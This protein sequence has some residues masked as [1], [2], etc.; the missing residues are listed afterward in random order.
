VRVVLVCGTVPED[1]AQ[2]V[3]AGLGGELAAPGRRVAVVDDPTRPT[4]RRQFALARRPG[5]AEV[6]RGENSLDETLT[7]VPGV[8]SLYVLRRRSRAL[9]WARGGRGG[10]RPYATR[11]IWWSWPARRCLER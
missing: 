4:L 1:Y 2:Q 8:G 11:S 7:P 3:A 9:R 6:A 5:W 10:G